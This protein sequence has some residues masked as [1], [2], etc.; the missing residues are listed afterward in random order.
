MNK[1]KKLYKNY[2]PGKWEAL[3]FLLIPVLIGLLNSTCPN[4]D[5][6]FLLATGREILKNGF[7]TIDPFT[8]HS[9]LY[10][11]AQQWLFDV[12]FYIIYDWF[13]KIGLYIFMNIFGIITVFLTYKLLMLVTDNNRN[14]AIRFTVIITSIY[15]MNYFLFR[16]QII[17]TPLLLLELYYLEKYFKTNNKKCLIALPIISV[18]TINV[19]AAIWPMTILFMIPFILNTFSYKLG[20]IGS[21][22][23]DKKPLL[24]ALLGMFLAGF[25]NPYGIKA[26]IYLKNSIKVE[27]LSEIVGEMKPLDVNF[28]YGKVFFIIIILI[29]LFYIIYK[30]KVQARHIFLLLGTTYLTLAANRGLLF[31]IITS[32]YPVAMY[33]NKSLKKEKDQNTGKPTFV[34]ALIVL[35][36]IPFIIIVKSDVI[37]LKNGIE[38]HIDFIYEQENKNTDNIRLYCSY[39]V[40]TYAEYIGI[41]PY[42]DA[43]AELF[44]IENNKKADIIREYFYLQNNGVYYKDFLNKYDFNYLIVNK[45]DYLYFNLL[46]D[47]D[48]EL[49]YKDECRPKNKLKYAISN[50]SDDGWIYYIFKKKEKNS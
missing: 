42:L 50:E 33:L 6:W 3:S 5:V 21:S 32:I 7:F 11:I 27:V 25:V 44:A 9:G 22:K 17:S 2:H 40:C 30:N 45:F 24:L 34:F 28:T 1:L 41:K 38:D 49:I 29:Y 37:S 8:I 19:H 12:I 43:R 46:H 16:P 18:V 4:D 39:A 20:K 14:N 10:T 35:V 13:G 47:D 26:I 36:I 15:Y 23:R 48:Y 31:L